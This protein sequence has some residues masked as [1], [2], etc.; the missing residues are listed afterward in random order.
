MVVRTYANVSIQR[1]MKEEQLAKLTELAETEA[2]AAA[3]LQVM[4][5]SKV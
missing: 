4:R 1:K 3:T 5:A 2:E